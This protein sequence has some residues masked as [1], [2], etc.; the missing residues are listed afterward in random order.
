MTL[1]FCDNNCPTPRVTAKAMGRHLMPRPWTPSRVRFAGRAA[2]VESLPFP[3][4][5]PRGAPGFPGTQMGNHS[6]NEVRFRQSKYICELI[7]QHKNAAK[8]LMSML[9]ISSFALSEKVDW[10]RP[11]TYETCW[12]PTQRCLFPP[13]KPDLKVLLCEFSE[14]AAQ[15]SY[16]LT[17]WVKVFQVPLSNGRYFPCPPVFL[18]DKKQQ[19]NVPHEFS[20]NQGLTF[21]KMACTKKG[22]KSQEMTIYKGFR[23]VSFARSIS[24]YEENE[25]ESLSLHLGSSWSYFKTL[26]WFQD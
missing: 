22:K 8:I 10:L 19:S 24:A 3:C 17:F 16:E 5:T 23:M 14:D 13:N 9:T 11:K 12:Q 4:V 2:D 15:S 26:Q 25:R 6:T 18:G 7:K 21:P 20:F 1:A